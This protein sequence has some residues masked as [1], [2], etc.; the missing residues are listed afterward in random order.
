MNLTALKRTLSWM[1]L[2]A[3]VGWVT[4][5]QGGVCKL[6]NQGGDGSCGIWADCN[7]PYDTYCAY[8]RQCEGGYVSVSCY[9]PGQYSCTTGQTSTSDGVTCTARDLSGDIICTY[10]DPCKLSG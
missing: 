9:C 4:M 5:V 1:L 6:C 10:T 7:P 2:Y 3:F 8:P